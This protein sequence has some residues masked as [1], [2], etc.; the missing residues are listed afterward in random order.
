LNLVF[1]VLDQRNRLMPSEKEL[2]KIADE[3]WS[4]PVEPLVRRTSAVIPNESFPAGDGTPPL[5]NLPRPR[6]KLIAEEVRTAVVHVSPAKAE[7]Y[8]QM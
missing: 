3:I 6:M 5:W 2:A 4:V 7:E 8:C 1:G